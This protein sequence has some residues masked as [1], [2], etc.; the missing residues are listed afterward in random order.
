MSNNSISRYSPGA[1]ATTVRW[2][3]FIIM[4]LLGAINYIDRTSLAIAMPY[5][6]EEFDIQDAVV[7]GLLHSTFFWAYALMQIPSGVL[8]DRFKTR[9]IIAWATIIWGA[10][11]AVAALCYSTFTLAIARVGLGVSEAPIMPSGAK[12][13][14][15]WLT[16]T[17]RGRGSM[18]LDGGAALGTALGAVIL[19]WLIAFFGSWRMAFVVAGIGTIMAGLLAWWY[20]RTYP[21]EH[22]YINK[23]ELDHI[24][25]HNPTSVESGKKFKLSDIKPY[26]KQRNVLAL[27]GGWVCYST[28]FY[29]LMTWL[30]LYFQKTYGFDIK[31]MGGAMAF[32]FLLCFIGQL[33]GGYIMDRWRN[34]GAKTN[35]VLHTMLAISAITAGV[36][37]F[38]CANSSDP[39]LA[40]GLLAVAMFPLRW[41][42]VYWSI[43]SLLGAQKV[44]GTIC[45]TMNFSSNLFAAII[46]I[47]I[48]FI[49]QLTGNYYAA[50]MVFVL[51][52]VGYLICSLMINFD[53]PVIVT[54]DQA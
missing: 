36:G 13:M 52:A 18:L 23:A 7:V 10:F 3:I 38:L 25:E 11:Q 33:T 16:P 14:G 27:I 49:V 44:A 17:E 30:P 9:T 29:G 4:L 21:H 41:A 32:I 37:I 51:A 1:A 45:G 53:K 5:I 48:G 20:I 19:T 15:A 8:A 34:S 6:V 2:K 35:K 42:S 50:M 28:V 39:M 22:P 43:P 12:L 24:T 31:S 40:V 26:L 47:F 54:E 46:P